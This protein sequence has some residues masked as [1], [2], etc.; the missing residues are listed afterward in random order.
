MIKGPERQRDPRL[1]FFRGAALFVIYV[2]HTSYNWLWDYIPARFGLS[3]AADMFVFISGYAAAIA[4]GGTFVRAGFLTGMARVLNRCWQ[5]YLAHLGLLFAIIALS[6][7]G[8]KLFGGD[9]LTP[10]GIDRL[11]A[12]PAQA[13]F[14]MFTLSYVPRYL[15][16]LPLYLVLLSMIP[17]AMLL[18][19]IAN[20]LPLA[21]SAAIYLAAQFIDLDFI[22]D[23]GT[24]AEWLFN[25]FAWQLIFYTG[26]SLSRGWVKPPRLMLPLA[27][28]AALLVIFAV[29]VKVTGGTSGLGPL[30]AASTWVLSHADKRNLDPLRFAHFLALAYLVVGVLK[31][32]EHWLAA[33][34]AQPILTLGRQGLAVFITVSLA[35]IVSGILFE[36]IGTGLLAQ[37]GINLAAFLTF[38]GVARGVGWLK[39]SP[40][41]A[42]RAPLKVVEADLPVLEKAA[43]D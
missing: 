8:Q 41:K 9:Y 10:L 11:M 38:Y 36:Q 17:A 32:H 12:E 43:A 25:P 28:P 5:L 29:F 23:R 16:I 6:V 21:A 27:I 3:D 2:A 18:V 34:W 14:E 15:D 24:G 37:I 1:D 26:F 13:I 20:W 40:W 42:R 33:R 30:D 22:A 7:T 4:F 19:R 35:S 39:S 31:G